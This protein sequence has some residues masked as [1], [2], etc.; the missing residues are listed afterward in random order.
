MLMNLTKVVR[1]EFVHAY[2]DRAAGMPII[3]MTTPEKVCAILIIAKVFQ[4]IQPEQLTT[5]FGYGEVYL[6][7]AAAVLTMTIS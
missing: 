5:T 3:P 7:L 6:W 2:Q 4:S 1:I